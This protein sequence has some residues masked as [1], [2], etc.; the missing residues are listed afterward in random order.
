[1]CEVWRRPSQWLTSP[2]CL[3]PLSCLSLP[4]H[5]KVLEVKDLFTAAGAFNRPH[6]DKMS[7]QCEK[8]VNYQSDSSNLS[9][10]NK[11]TGWVMKLSHLNLCLW[12][13]H[14]EVLVNVTGLIMD[15]QEDK[16]TSQSFLPA[17]KHSS[18]SLFSSL[19]QRDAAQF[20]LCT[21]LKNN[22]AVTEVD[23]AALQHRSR[24]DKMSNHIRDF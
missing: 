16:N 23:S 12:K 15:W 1:M 22:P 2:L 20:S 21:T 13:V 18:E 3:V 24:D 10:G 11:S 8:A 17:D 6:Y 14:L 9:E 7:Q 5:S 19:W 4:L